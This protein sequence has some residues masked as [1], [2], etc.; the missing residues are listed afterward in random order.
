MR[1]LI[2]V[3]MLMLSI[4]LVACG[5]KAG[6]QNEAGREIKTAEGSYRNISPAQLSAML[7]DKNFLLVNVH[8][9]YEGEI[10]PT[11]LFIPY[12]EV[13]QNLARFPRNKGEKIVLYCRSGSMSAIA[14]RT[15]VRLGF[16][17]VWN[18]DGG[19]LAWA[20]EGYTIN[21]KPRGS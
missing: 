6:A 11:D 13:E 5:G 19:M 16:S 7:K 9:P 18:L 14:A 1:H 4:L 2:A 10:S 12:N 20:K 8:I 17:N 21:Q 15:L 3:T